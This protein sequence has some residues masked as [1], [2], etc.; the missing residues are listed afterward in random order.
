MKGRKPM[1]RDPKRIDNVIH[2]LEQFWRKHPDWRL[3]QI[4]CNALAYAYVYAYFLNASLE[5]VFYMEDD[6]FLLGLKDMSKK[7]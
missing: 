6:N 5:D 7:L 4:V 1:P 2:E 3:G